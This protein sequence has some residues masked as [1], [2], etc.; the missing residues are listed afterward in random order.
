MESH[1]KDHLYENQKPFKR[2]NGPGYGTVF[3]REDGSVFFEPVQLK[4]PYKA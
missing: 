1:Q 2:M 4:L 3:L